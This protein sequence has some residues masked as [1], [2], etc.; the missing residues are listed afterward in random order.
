MTNFSRV[1]LLHAILEMIEEKI[2]LIL[3]V[4]YNGNIEMPKY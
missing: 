4:R 1:R 2:N 3:E